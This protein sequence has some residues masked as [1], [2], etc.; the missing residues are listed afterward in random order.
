MLLL[1]PRRPAVLHR[2]HINLSLIARRAHP[3]T[4]PPRRKTRPHHRDLRRDDPHRRLTRAP[5]AVDYEPRAERD[6][7]QRPE[8]GTVYEVTTSV[9]P[10][11]ALLIV[12]NTGEKITPQLVATLAEPFLRGPG[13]I[14]TEHAGVGLGLALV[15]SIT[16]AH[17]GT[18]T[19]TPRAA[20]GLCVRRCNYP[21]RHR[22]LADDDRGGGAR[23][24]RSRFKASAC[25]SAGGATPPAPACSRLT[26]LVGP[27]A[28]LGNGDK[29]QK[30]SRGR[31]SHLD[32]GRAHGVLSSCRSRRRGSSSRACPEG[33]PAARPATPLRVAKN[34]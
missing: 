9:H 25:S 14:R 3:N 17:D 23:T 1:G 26:S 8:Q 15:K 10:K 18:L 11:R 31:K 6:R 4:P 20:G 19:L 7:P 22:T 13:R 16:Q 27:A 30:S 29:G 24:E 2:E 34:G 21:P 28:L 12:E 33:G 5:A 32:R